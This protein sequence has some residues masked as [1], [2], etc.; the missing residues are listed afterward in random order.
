MSNSFGH[1][2]TQQL[3][4]DQRDSLYTR[5]DIRI[6]H[7]QHLE[8]QLLKEAAALAEQIQFLQDRRAAIIHELHSRASDEEFQNYLESLKL[9][10]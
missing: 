2:T 8:N 1:M 6:A 10:D 9:A 7:K 4:D 3:L 5:R